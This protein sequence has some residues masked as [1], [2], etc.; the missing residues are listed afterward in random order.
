MKRYF[1]LA[2]LAIALC[3]VAQAQ[4]R[5]RPMLGLDSPQP[6][7]HLTSGA[8]LQTNGHEKVRAKKIGKTVAWLERHG[9]GIG[10]QF[11]REAAE[12]AGMEDHVNAALLRAKS[13]WRACGY[14]VD[15][16]DWSRLLIT[17]EALPF[18]IA[19]YDS[20]LRFS[21]SVEGDHVRLVV[22][23]AREAGWLQ[24]YR[25]L[26]FWEANNFIQCKLLGCPRTIEGEV[27]AQRPCGSD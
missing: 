17:V 20:S 22:F 8:A 21:G 26:A 14:N 3:A 19:G 13:N 11:G 4:E 2:I 7:I 6:L 16:I 18:P 24:T 9:Y 25:E 23:N 5:V 15:S 1:S 12:V 27:A 10:P